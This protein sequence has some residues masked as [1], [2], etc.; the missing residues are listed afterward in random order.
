M[1]IY[2]EQRDTRRFWDARYDAGHII[3]TTG[4]LGG[5]GE[6]DAPIPCDEAEAGARLRAL[7]SEQSTAGFL[8]QRPPEERWQAEPVVGAWFAADGL[9]DE[10][11]PR[12]PRPLADAYAEALGCALPPEMRAFLDW[13]AARTLKH[14]SWGEWR[15]HAEDEWLPDPAAGNRFEQVVLR[16]QEN[17]LGTRLIEYFTGCVPL[18]DAGNGD[19]YLAHVDVM[20]PNSAEVMFWNHET[21]F[22]ETMCADGISTLAWVNRWYRA[23]GAGDFEPE[24][25]TAAMER[26]ADRAALSWHYN[27][28]ESESGVEPAFEH[29]SNA[30]YYFYRA[31]WIM[32][33]LQSDGVNRL[34][35]IP[36]LFHVK[37][38]AQQD[39]ETS[40]AS[41][42]MTVG[43]VTALYWLWRLFWFD[44][45]EQLTRCI[46]RLEGH[47]SPVVRDAAALVAELQAGRKTL[48]KI[49]DIHALRER[50]LAFDL[51]PDRAA[52]REAEKAAAEAAAEAKIAA[53]Q[54]RATAAIVGLDAAGLAALA[55][56]EV[57][58]PAALAVIREALRP[59][60]P[61]AFVRLDFMAARGWSRDG[62]SYGF[63]GDEIDEILPAMAPWMAPF[64]L[65]EGGAAHLTRAARTGDPRLR[66]RL[67]AALAE[68][69][70]YH[71]RVVAAIEGLT[72]LGA[73]DLVPRFVEMLGEFSWSGRDFMAALKNKQVVWA[74]CAAIG[75]MGDADDA[76]PLIEMAETGPKDLV[77]RALKA[78]GA[79][80]GD[81]AVEALVAALD[82]PH[83]RLAMHALAKADPA[84]AVAALE[85]RLATE[86]GPAS[87]LA[88]ERLMLAWAQQQ[89]GRPFDLAVV[90]AAAAIIEA[91]KYEDIEL[92]QTLVAMAPG[93]PQRVDLARR[94]AFHP[95]RA[96]REAAADARPIATRVADRPTVVALHARE[97]LAGLAAWLAD[98]AVLFKHNLLRFAVDLDA[99]DD[100]FATAAVAW[101]RADLGRFTTYTHGFVR[102]DNP[103]IKYALQALY[104][105]E[106]PIID[107]LLIELL[108]GTN[109]MFREYVRKADRAGRLTAPTPTAVDLPLEFEP[110]G[111][112]LWAYGG[113]INGLAWSPDGS[114]LALAGSSGVACF[115]A[116]GREARRFGATANGWIYDVAWHPSGEY[117]AM[118]AHAGHLF[119]LDPRSGEKIAA[120]KGHGGVPNG[121]RKL[122]FS[123]D[124]ARLASVSCDR[125]LRVWDV[126]AVKPDTP[127][128]C[129]FVHR[130]KADVNGVD[131][132]SAD[133]LVI[134]TDNAVHFMKCGEAPFAS[135]H[136]CGG[137]DVRVDHANARVWATGPDGIRAFDLE[138]TPLPEETL[139]QTSVARL[140]P[141]PD[142]LV[143]ASWS[144][145][146]TGVSVWSEGTRA[147]LPGHTDGA[148]FGA[149]VHPPSGRIFAGGK[150]NRIVSWR[151]GALEAADRAAHSNEVSDFALDGDRIFTASDD[152]TVIEWDADGR[153]LRRLTPSTGGRCCAVAVTDDAIVT[154][155]S[156]QVVAFDRET[157][158]ER[159]AIEVGRSEVCDAFGD[160]VVA[161]D[162][163]S[164]TWIDLKTGERLH[165][166]E[167]FAQSFMFRYARLD[168]RRFVCAGYDDVQLYVW[169]AIARKQIGVYRLPATAEK[170][171]IC[172][173]ALGGGRLFVT[174]W[175]KT[176]IVLD[177]AT[178]ALQARVH[179]PHAL[180]NP[181][182]SPD[183]SRV[184]AG[185]SRCF[186][187]E[188]EG[189]TQMGTFT[190]PAKLSK[191]VFVGAERVLLG[192]GSGALSRTVLK[193]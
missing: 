37:I 26:V 181:A 79:L 29:R 46:A 3:V 39:F 148:V 145:D 109:A 161:A 128:E 142:G 30:I 84:R 105:L 143:A 38:N 4:A 8:V 122:R 136:R 71:H 132:L 74:L 107:A 170:G 20:A 108:G 95:R 17:Y 93:L 81:A 90:D 193:G 185:E 92:H 40:V 110:F 100:A 117:L 139:A 24:T 83:A 23:V 115:H 19:V 12:T 77:P 91:Q 32:R 5:D 59:H 106:H 160:V 150:L 87:A 190:P 119:L 55:W 101:W 50:F 82:G 60:H 123:P 186:V 98:P 167:P 34:S 52:A 43:P 172:G 168:D 72:A 175:D 78:L 36:D 22:P 137:A 112:A 7:Y 85:D 65:A 153:S 127:V 121:V 189:Y 18:G 14:A 178:G 9:P 130:D 67:E 99:I 156:K 47:P 177:A 166:S 149:A 144:G 94:L 140:I 118:G 135:I 133:R 66:P 16:D 165:T 89:V 63:E 103:A 48:G 125:T 88:Y 70:E 15:L 176:M 69:A 28:L 180:L 97:G 35:E 152:G 163:K 61:E 111:D 134:I 147:R 31:I 116:D 44:K 164:L 73:T 183:G 68:R 45:G 131:W 113:S 58:N 21:R 51:D 179:L 49:A 2:A 80:G 126:S 42:F 129:V 141:T 64:W 191:T 146:D 27:D 169:D 102:D 53:D 120:L 86:F 171:K 155:G 76:A 187:F 157:G 13:R 56:D 188:T 184:V 124:G 114:L 41:P 151:D 159:W 162:Y 138:G 174:R 62:R 192:A 6:T 33:L 104:A 57:D 173:L 10:G 1:R 25:L 75:A 54:A 158:A 11:E 154:S 96:V 182:A